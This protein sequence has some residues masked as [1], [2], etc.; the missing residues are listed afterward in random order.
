M[1]LSPHG[2]VD[3]SVE[4][5]VVFQVFVVTPQSM[6]FRISGIPERFHLKLGFHGKL[7]PSIKI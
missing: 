1:L 4:L 6:I 7:K 5:T 2:R 3:T